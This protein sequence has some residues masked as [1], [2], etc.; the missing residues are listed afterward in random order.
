LSEAVKEIQQLLDYLAQT[1][2]ASTESEKTAVVKEIEQNPKI[3]ERII[4]ALGQG[5]KTA[6]ETL[7]NHPAASIAIAVYDGWKA[8]KK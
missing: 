5:G 4:S 6:L 1:Y 2:P 7:V 8:P 3:K